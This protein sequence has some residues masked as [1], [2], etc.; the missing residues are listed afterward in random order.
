MSQQ[1]KG[2]RVENVIE[3]EQGWFYNVEFDKFVLQVPIDTGEIMA[4][5]QELSFSIDKALEVYLNA[6]IIE[7]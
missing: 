5:Q 4:I 6:Y 2:I 3:Y 1:L 7:Q